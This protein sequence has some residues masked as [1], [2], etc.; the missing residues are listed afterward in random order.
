MTTRPY[1]I[2]NAAG[3]ASL[4]S[5]LIVFLVAVGIIP[6]ADGDVL[7]RAAGSFITAAFALGGAL[8]TLVAHRTAKTKTTAASDPMA[9][10]R[11]PDGS[12][13]LEPL[14]PVSLAMTMPPPSAGVV[15]QADPGPY[16]H[17]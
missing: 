16:D 2:T 12:T 8:I 9:E 14:V 15:E 4:V 7:D 5:T 11:Q 17:I 6:A 3:L 1:P 10:V 13:V